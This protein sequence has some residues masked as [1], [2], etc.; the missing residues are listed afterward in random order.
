[1]KRRNKLIPFFRNLAH[2]DSLA[3][4]W[5]DS[6]PNPNL[7]RL[8]KSSMAHADAEPLSVFTQNE[9]TQIM[10]Q[11]YE[12]KYPKLKA[13][14]LIPLKPGMNPGAMSWSFDRW[15]QVGEADWIGGNAADFNRV[16]V[17]K[18]RETNP[19][20]MIAIAYGY[21]VEELLAAQFAGV[22]LD[23]RKANAAMRA[24][25][26]KENTILL[27][28]DSGRGIPGLLTESKIPQIILPFG[29]WTAA[30]AADNILADMN[31]VANA[32]W[33]QSAE[34]HE[35]NTLLMS[36]DDYNIVS[37]KPRSTTSDTTVLEYFLRTSPF[38][39]DVRPLREM[40]S[41]PGIGRC[42]MAYE[43]DPENLEGVVSL[44][45]QQQAPQT[46]ALE[47]LVPVLSKQGGTV[48]YFPFAACI[49]QM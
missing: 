39:R 24:M 6:C 33:I 23:Q 37:Q 10:T 2:L 41:V 5:V 8:F 30:T 19:I 4:S 9:L 3:E 34:N 38:I 12:R 45:P 15:N 26:V 44:P 21:S 32:V 42:L 35:P 46:R 17:S 16:D 49:G 36:L 28:G 11:A 22:P 48:W 40:G 25:M 7:K 27:Y 47:T 13:R 43:R 18:D 20:R 31:A 1:M 14:E 29:D